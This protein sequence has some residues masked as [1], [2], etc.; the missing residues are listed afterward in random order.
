MASQTEIS[1]VIVNYNAGQWLARSVNA[2][3]DSSMPV[4]LLVVDNNSVDD[5]LDGISQPL[6]QGR[7]QL[8][9]N[10]DNQGYGR[11]C[12]QLLADTR[13]EYFLLLNPDCVLEKDTV[14][15]LQQCLLDEPDAAIAGALVLD[16]DGGEQRACRR[17]EPSPKRSIVTMLGLETWF[18]GAGVNMREPLPSSCTPVDAV[19][20][21]L[22]LVR[23]ACFRQLGGFDEAYF[24]HCED[25]DL[26]RRVRDAGWQIL[27]Q[28]KARAQHAKGV[29]QQSAPLPSERHKHA[30]MVRYFRTYHAAG[31][32]FVARVWPLL[33]WAHY[34]VMAPII[35]LRSWFRR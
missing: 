6:K 22:L 32:P 30:G 15:Q 13:A 19:S 12:N 27:F 23:A 29:S 26:F 8:I 35:Q 14:E 17:R 1:A 33:I 7:L 11:A 31:H 2:L 25:L 28:P 9:R 16:V 5:S 24:L 21:A 10:P 4:Q 20:G 18:P 34:G 3:L